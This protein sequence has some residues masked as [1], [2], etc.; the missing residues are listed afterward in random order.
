MMGTC[1]KEDKEI[2]FLF[3]SLLRE[4]ICLARPNG[5]VS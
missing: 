1:G 2:Q 5:E 4:E 3:A